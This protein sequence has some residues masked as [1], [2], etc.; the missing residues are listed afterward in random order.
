MNADAIR[1]SLTDSS[2]NQ[3]AEQSMFISVMNSLMYYKYI[4][5]CS[6]TVFL[7]STG[8]YELTS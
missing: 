3:L 7:L 4:G 6:L 5:S 8:C 2:V 1:K